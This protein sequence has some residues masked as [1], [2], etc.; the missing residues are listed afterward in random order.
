[1]SQGTTSQL[2]EKGQPANV[3]AIEAK[4]GLKPKLICGHLRPD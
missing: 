4:Q 2:A 1:M 3:S